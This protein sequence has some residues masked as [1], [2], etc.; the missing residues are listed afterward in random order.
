MVEVFPECFGGYFHHLM[1]DICGEYI[2]H[3]FI[4]ATGIRDR[5]TADI[6]LRKGLE[7]RWY[8]FNR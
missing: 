7:K 6:L 8:E 3:D 4:Y 2:K 1:V 5:K